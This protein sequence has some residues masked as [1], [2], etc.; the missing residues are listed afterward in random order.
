MEAIQIRLL[1]VD[2]NWTSIMVHMAFKPVAGS[3][4]GHLSQDR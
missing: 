2:N 1:F 3:K 4:L